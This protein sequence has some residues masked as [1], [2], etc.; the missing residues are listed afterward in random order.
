MN[1]NMKE[2]V[3][4][5]KGISEKKFMIY[6]PLNTFD[7]DFKSRVKI[8]QFVLTFAQARRMAE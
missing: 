4:Q 8:T 2:I 6:W 1:K 7:T 5:L 3:F